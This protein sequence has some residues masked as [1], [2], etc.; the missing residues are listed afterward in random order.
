MRRAAATRHS[1]V[2][3]QARLRELQAF[4]DI[5]A[6]VLEAQGAAATAIADAATAWRRADAAAERAR[7]AQLRGEVFIRDPVRAQIGAARADLLA[8]RAYRRALAQEFEAGRVGLRMVLATGAP[9]DELRFEERGLQPPRAPG[10]ARGLWV[11]RSSTVLEPEPGADL[12]AFALRMGMTHLFVRTGTD[13]LRDEVVAWRRFLER[14]HAAGLRVHALGGAPSWA[15]PEGL[16]RALDF[17]KAVALFNRQAPAG[18]RFDALH[19][20]VEPHALPA[21]DEAQRQT[22]LL[23]GLLQML[24]QIR[25]LEPSVR[26]VHADVPAWFAR[27]EYAGASLLQS[28]G[29]R[30]DGLVLMAY[31]A[32]PR[33]VDASLRAAADALRG[34]GVAWWAGVSADPRHRCAGENGVAFEAQLRTLATAFAVNRQMRGIAVHDYGR[35]AA[36]QNSNEPGTGAC[37]GRLTQVPGSPPLNK[38]SADGNPLH[39][40]P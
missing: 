19:L 35:L 25:A 22:E 8:V 32:D 39:Q 24:D 12:L 18:A 34:S 6:S 29:R 40:T 30:V 2:I 36:L 23:A 17:A 15:T 16:P 7:L 31:A 27:R 5:D 38:E 4:H 3:E 14:A 10:A 11:W 9:V 20:D 37:A 26:E 1:A 28:L 33:R 13:G 21:W